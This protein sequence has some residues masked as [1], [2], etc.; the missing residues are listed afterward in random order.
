MQIA[1]SG[2]TGF[3]GRYLSDA[4]LRHGYQTVPLTRDDFRRSADSLKSKL[5]GCEAVIN[6]AG[7]PIA[8]RWTAAYKKIL[9]DSRIVTTRAIV[10]ALGGLQERPKVLISASGTGIYR[11]EGIHTEEDTHYADGFLGRLAQDWEHEALCAQE[12]GVRTV[13]FRF[14]VVL[15][16]NG[17][18]L[19]RMLPLFRLGLGGRLGS[20]TQPFSWVHIADLTSAIT[21]AVTD[22][23]LTGIY[24][25]TAPHPTTNAVFTR[26][27]SALLH[28]PA[29]LT[30]P[31][32]ALKLQ[33]GEAASV[34]LE[35]QHVLP[36]RLLAAGFCFAFPTIQEALSDLLQKRT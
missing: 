32:W 30:V 12:F 18:A 3:I 6:L 14:G 23:D 4:F 21:R 31:A 16:R 5:N 24:N 28:R 1:I 20:G 29:W 26:I 8:A 7:A 9:Y 35:G 17:G 33:F 36:T 10:A 13:V 11:S 25:L 15:G 27:L 22:P 34:L 2:S 19:Q